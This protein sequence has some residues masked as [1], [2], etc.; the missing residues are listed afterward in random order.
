MLA[1]PVIR[2]ALAAAPPGA[3]H[4]R[5]KLVHFAHSTPDLP[6]HAPWS[7]RAQMPSFSSPT[8]AVPGLNHGMQALP[9]SQGASTPTVQYWVTQLKLVQSQLLFGAQFMAGLS[10]PAGTQGPMQPKQLDR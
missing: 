4:F 3:G 6:T 5:L 2:A 1:R 10:A 8:G 7:V 9:T